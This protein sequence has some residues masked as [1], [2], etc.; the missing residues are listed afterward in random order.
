MITT[1][2]VISQASPVSLKHKWSVFHVVN[3]LLTGWLFICVGLI[4][5]FAFHRFVPY[6]MDEFAQYAQLICLYYPLN[7]LDATCGLYDLTI[8][9]TNI[10]LPLR[11][12]GYVGSLQNL[13]YLPL[14]ILW[15]SPMSARLVG[16]L[17][18]G[19]QALF[20]SR[21][22][23]IRKGAALAGLIIFFPY[24]FIHIIDTGPVAL[25]TTT[26]I[27]IYLLSDRWFK[28]PS[29]RYP[30]AIGLLLFVGFWTRL[31]FVWIVP[32]IVILICMK[33]IE[34]RAQIRDLRNTV[35]IQIT[36]AAIIAVSL[37]TVLL[38]STSSHNPESRPLLNY[39]LTGER[40]SLHE[41]FLKLPTLTVT[42]ILIDPFQATHR[43]FSVQPPSSLSFLYSGLLYFIIPVGLL[44]FLTFLKPNR[45]ICKA[46]VL[47]GLFVL[48]F[49][50]IAITKRA[51][52]MHH[53]VLAFPFLILCICELYDSA[54]VHLCNN[55][56]LYMS[57]LTTIIACFLL[58]NTAI[59][60]TF[61]TQQVTSYNDR[62]NIVLA[63]LLADKYLATDY[64]FVHVSWGAYY[65]MGLFGNNNQM[66]LFQQTPDIPYLVS[67]SKDYNRKLLFI[68]NMKKPHNQI[69]R[70]RDNFTLSQCAALDPKGS[71]QIVLQPDDNDDNICFH[72][73]KFTAN[74]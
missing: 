16:Y 25:H 4:I 27:L 36:L 3:F 34:H 20:L 58:L 47:Y 26:V 37:S 10:S 23:H 35:A 42:N 11:I 24:L 56:R 57:G 71:W 18:L 41:L 12:F 21:L 44:A 46:Y 52:A 1:K 43:I 54:R 60:V 15:K 48:T 28:N 53:I 68:Y 39:L 61:P 31:N 63:E 40:Y 72:P 19:L 51:N 74:R 22:F 73:E 55:R 70:V 50:I 62:S 29:Y 59:F 8:P 30:I 33:A 32:G 7:A 14:F 67:L 5:I 9:G 6:N 13:Y 69:T 49:L 2:D 64:I 38:L 45:K 66:T 17:F 65:H